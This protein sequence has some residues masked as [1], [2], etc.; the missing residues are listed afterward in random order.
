MFVQPTGRDQGQV[1]SASP[2]APIAILSPGPGSQATSP[3]KLEYHLS[4]GRAVSLRIELYGADGRLLARQVR[5]APTSTA[6]RAAAGSATM[7]FEIHGQSENARLVVLAADSHGKPLAVSSVDLLLLAEGRSKIAPQDDHQPAIVI[8]EP[9]YGSTLSSGTLRVAGIART[10]PAEPLHVEL[11]TREGK[12][13]AQRLAKLDARNAA[14][15][16]PFSTE[17]V[18]KVAQPTPARLVV[19]ADGA[20]MTA[21]THLSSLDITLAPVVSASTFPFLSLSDKLSRDII[22]KYPTGAC[23]V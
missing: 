18:Y 4:E 19:F 1:A 6:K 3:I 16:A 22:G 13:L 15:D 23:H 2:Q 9:V 12:L 5:R 14:G 10:D 20:P 11:R 8:L 17:L 7:E 21:F